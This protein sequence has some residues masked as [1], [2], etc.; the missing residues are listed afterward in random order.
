MLAED[1]F[2]ILLL[3]ED[4]LGSLGCEIV[5][6]A[7]NLNSALD[8]AERCD[9]DAAVLDVNLAGQAVYPVAEALKRRNIPMVFCSGYGKSGIDP[10][11]AD[12]PVV[13]K[14]FGET[15]L[16]RALKQAVSPAPTEA[17]GTT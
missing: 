13:Q 4:M 17:G 7:S 3:L 8:R 2:H 5:E 9:I 10:A 16:A 6:T 1:E 11:W 15:L 12:Y 14:P